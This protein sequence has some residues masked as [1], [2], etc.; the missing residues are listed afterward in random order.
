MYKITVASQ[1]LEN[2][3]T[4]V[5]SVR[6]VDALDQVN[7]SERKPDPHQVVCGFLEYKCGQCKSHGSVT[8][9][10]PTPLCAS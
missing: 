5:P 6:R 3:V 4:F 7:S 1:M 2:Q 8:Q 10:T 9:E